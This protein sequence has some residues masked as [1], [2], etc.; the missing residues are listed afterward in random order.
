MTFSPGQT[1]L[2]V[3]GDAGSRDTGSQTRAQPVATCQ[4]SRSVLCYGTRARRA[5][6]PDEGCL[7]K[8]AKQK[9]ATDVSD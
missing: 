2:L 4:R 1:S 3:A 6:L 5:I 9:C 7:A 8:P